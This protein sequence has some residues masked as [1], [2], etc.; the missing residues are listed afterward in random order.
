MFA[1]HVLEHAYNPQQAVNEWLRVAKHQAYFVIEVP[2]NYPTNEIDKI[3]FKT[4]PNLKKLFKKV[5]MKIIWSRQL[6]NGDNDNFHETDIISI[7][8]QID[9]K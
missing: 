7:I 2:V 5:K 9:K 4:I 1:S 3:D 6:K 8:F